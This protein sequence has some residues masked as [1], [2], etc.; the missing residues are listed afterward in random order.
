MVQDR[1]DTALA[2]NVDWASKTAEEN[3]ALFPTLASGQH[4]EI[5]W[6]GCADSR[7][8][9]TTILGLQPGDV[10]V[11]RNIAN[12][13][14]TSDLNSASVIEYAVVYLKVKHIVVCGHT[15][16]GGV[17]ASLA[18]KKLGL[19]DTW[20]LPLRRLRQE[21]LELLKTMTLEEGA[22]KIA[23]LNV[24]QG[25]RTLQENHVVLDAIEERGLKLHGLVY[26]VGSGKL[27][28]LES[29]EPQEVIKAR[30]TA[31]KTEI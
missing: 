23:E 4:P 12:I 15:S 7:C 17:A 11:H 29:D 1:F 19:I 31:F 9:E 26:D 30:L 20:L 14:Q 22:L 24:L 3:P 27:R 10:F 21:N 8:P 25:L 5:L 18:N 6:I 13:V 2:Q 16:C 28:E